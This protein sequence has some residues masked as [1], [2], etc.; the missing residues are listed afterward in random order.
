MAQILVITCLFTF[1]LGLLQQTSFTRHPDGNYLIE[2]VHLLERISPV[3]SSDAKN[4]EI[5]SRQGQPNIPS[6]N[7]NSTVL[8]ALFYLNYF[9]FGE[10]ENLLSSPAALKK[11]HKLTEKQSLW[12]AT[13]ARASRFQWKDCEELVLTKGNLFLKDLEPKQLCLCN[14]I[15]CKPLPQYRWQGINPNRLVPEICL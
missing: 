4:S 3:I 11:V 12:V 8:E 6:L 13:T 14:N 1:S 5:I 2:H 15:T 10:P 9:H 7:T